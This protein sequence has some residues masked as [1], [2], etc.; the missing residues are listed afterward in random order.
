MLRH[1]ICLLT[2]CLTIWPAAGGLSAQSRLS[3]HELSI[4]GFR[5][6][7][8][9]LEYRYR[10]VSAH[11]G[12]YLTNF[13]SGTT[14]QFVRCGVSLWFLPVGRREHPSSFY[15]SLSYLRG[16]NRDY[17]G[18]NALATEVGFRAMIWKGLQAR[19]GV[20]ALAAPD[21]PL[22]INPTPS[23]NYSFFF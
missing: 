17:R 2:C 12:Y 5:N 23:L 21:R 7:S 13:E 18:L 15:A 3:T 1:L 10:A 9:G 11:A 19:I 6:P 20:V 16:L 14:W 8:V 22:R 4:N